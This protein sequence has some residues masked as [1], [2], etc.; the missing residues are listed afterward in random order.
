MSL[1]SEDSLIPV[2]LQPPMPKRVLPRRERPTV[3][4]VTRT[5]VPVQAASKPAAS[6][7]SLLFGL[8]AAVVLLALPLPLLLDG[9]V[10]V[11]PRFTLLAALVIP[12][13][14]FMAVVQSRYGDNSAR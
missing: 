3:R 1:P 12:P 6:S 7:T 2:A 9:S 14:L 10:S 5:A 13:V 8:L 4:S 11:A